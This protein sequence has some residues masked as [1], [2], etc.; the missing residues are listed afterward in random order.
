MLMDTFKSA[1]LVSAAVLAC[2]NVPSGKAVAY[3]SGDTSAIAAADTSAGDGTGYPTR[4]ITIPAGTLLSLQMGSSV[5]SRSS[6]VEQPVSAT[7]RRPLVVRGVTVVP[8]GAPLSGYI[9]QVQ[10]SGRV[11]GRARI[12]VRFTTMR[13]GE[14]RY[15]IQ[16]AGITRQAPGTKKKDAMKIGIGA[17]AGALV[18]ALT[19]G[20]KGAAIGSGVGG[21]GGSALVLSTRGTEVGIGRGTVLTTR[22]SEPLTVRVR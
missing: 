2:S 21:A 8:A 20:K 3:A 6:R 16:T 10:R 9:N 22:L 1:L 11:K 13:V 7:L 17:G 12:G 4:E 15:R 14:T 18:G 19:G 5:S